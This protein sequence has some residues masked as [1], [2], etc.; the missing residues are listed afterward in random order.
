MCNVACGLC[1]VFHSPRV[2]CWNT[3]PLCQIRAEA[4]LDLESSRGSPRTCWAQEAVTHFATNMQFLVQNL[5]AKVLSFTKTC[6]STG[7][8]LHPGLARF[9]SSPKVNRFRLRAQACAG[10]E[11]TCVIRGPE[12]SVVPEPFNPPLHLGSSKLGGRQSALQSEPSSIC[13]DPR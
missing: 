3:D 7:I 8:M 2:P 10:L 4:L 12:V 13:L 11:W 6:L 9:V 1:A 5:S